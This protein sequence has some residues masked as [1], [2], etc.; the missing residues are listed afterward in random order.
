M[1]T[2]FTKVKGKKDGAWFSKK[3][4]APARF[5]R[6]AHRLR[7]DFWQNISGGA[8]KVKE[9]KACELPHKNVIGSIIKKGSLTDRRRYPKKYF[10]CRW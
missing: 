6:A 2:P 4:G 7:M 10:E 3:D 8:R 9:K 1:E 5:N